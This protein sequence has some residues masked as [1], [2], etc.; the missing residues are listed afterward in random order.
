MQGNF[1]MDDACFKAWYGWYENH[2][3]NPP[4]DSPMFAGYNE[5]K[6]LHALKL[7]M[8]MSAAR[9]S[10]R[11]I[12]LQD[13]ERASRTL[14]NAET[15]MPHVF[16][17]YGQRENASIFSD[18]MNVIATSRSITRGGL[19]NKF[20]LEISIDKLDEIVLTLESVGFCRRVVTEA[21]T[22]IEYTKKKT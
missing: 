2:E 11:I 12:T 9:D 21:D 14:A 20:L 22:Y 7:S 4:L 16:E 8:I 13:L 3:R 5:R 10:D 15:A 17:G 18:I 6:P 19:M 1:Q